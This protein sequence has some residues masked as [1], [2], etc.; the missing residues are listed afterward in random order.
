MYIFMLYY[1]KHENALCEMPH[2]PQN[3]CVFSKISF[4]FKPKI[5]QM[6]I[7]MFNVFI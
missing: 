3:V 7:I 1:V 4:V 5:R 6:H 2:R